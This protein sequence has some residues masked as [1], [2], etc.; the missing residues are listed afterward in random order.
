MFMLSEINQGT[1][2]LTLT[3]LKAQLCLVVI[4]KKKGFNVFVKNTALVW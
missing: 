4:E 3:L 2:S 1:P